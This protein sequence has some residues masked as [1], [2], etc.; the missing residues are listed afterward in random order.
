MLAEGLADVA[1]ASA[2]RHRAFS[3]QVDAFHAEL[4]RFFGERV[5]QGALLAARDY[6]A[7]PTFTFRE[8]PERSLVT[9]ILGSSVGLLL[10]A[11][12]ALLAARAG[13][14]RQ[15]ERGFR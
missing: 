15:V 7:M 11:V 3:E 4:R 8:P 5:E 14:R 13:L 2:A 10:P 9:R 6:D 12:A 1:G